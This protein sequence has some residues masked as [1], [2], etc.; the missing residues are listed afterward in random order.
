MTSTLTT[1]QPAL[2]ANTTPASAT[3]AGQTTGFLP[4]YRDGNTSPVVFTA[5]ISLPLSVDDLVAAVWVLTYGCPLDEIPLDPGERYGLPAMVMD[6]LVGNNFEVTNALALIP[7]IQPGSEDYALLCQVRA[8]VAQAFP[9]ASP[10]PDRA[11]RTR[12]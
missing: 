1:T 11:T 12:A 2:T 8:V 3:I 6:T 4:M 9:V 5:V 7:E 10:A